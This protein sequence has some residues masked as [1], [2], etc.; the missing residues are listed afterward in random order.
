MIQRRGFRLLVFPVD[1]EVAYP[2][3]PTWVREHWIERAGY[4]PRD[5]ARYIR[6]VVETT[7]L[8]GMKTSQVLGRGALLDE[9]FIDFQDA[10]L[11]AHET[12]NV[13][14]VIFRQ[15]VPAEF[16]SLYRI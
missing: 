2:D 14:V 10:S 6:R 4:S 9:M 12:P 16:H 3:L 7:A 5:V 11:I 15:M 1:G 8:S 13:L